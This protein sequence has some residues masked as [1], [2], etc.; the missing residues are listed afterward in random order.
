MRIMITDATDA[1]AT[2]ADALRA[3][4]H[5]VRQECLAG[6]LGG[7]ACAGLDIGTCALD[8]HVDV[9]IAGLGRTADCASAG[10]VC[11]RR[12][13]VPVVTVG[14]HDADHGDLVP[15]L[16]RA[17]TTV[18]PEIRRLVEAELARLAG[19]MDDPPEVRLRR[20]PDRVVVEALMPLGATSA[21]ASTVA[22][23]LHDALG[24]RRRWLGVVDIVVRHREPY[25]R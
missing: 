14:R 11:A 23:R 3:E 7:P 17:A 12:H 6:D 16:E 24:P 25:V 20:E 13:G 5:D 22:V 21:M 19:A 2:V 10:A 8:E 15:A 9:A 18:D 4:G 1:A